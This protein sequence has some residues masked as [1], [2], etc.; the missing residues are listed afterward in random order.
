MARGMAHRELA[1]GQGQRA[2]V[3][4]L[5]HVVRLAEGEPAEQ[6][7]ADVER[8]ALGRVGEE[9]TVAGWMYAGMP[10]A[11]QTGATDHTWSR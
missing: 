8:E 9:L 2:A 6:L 10:L 4:Q 3:R 7:L 11:P 1:A 5:P